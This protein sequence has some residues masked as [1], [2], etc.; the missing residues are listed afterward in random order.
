MLQITDLHLD[1]L[2]KENS[3]TKCNRPLCCRDPPSKSEKNV[4][5]SG[6]YG[7]EGSCDIGEDLFRAF[8]SDASKKD[9]D[10]III[11]GDIVPHDLWYGSQEHV[12]NTTEKIMDMIKEGFKNDIPIYPILGNHEKYPNDLYNDEKGEAELLQKMAEVYRQFLGEEAYNSFKQYGYY[13]M[14]YKNTNLRIVAI[15]CLLCDSMNF[16]LISSKKQRT[17]EMLEWLE[18]VLQNAEDDGEYVYVLNH[19]PLN[20]DFS[21]TECAKRLHALLDRYDYIIR[22]VFSGHTH[23]DDVCQISEY[24]NKSSIINVNFVAPAL[25]T[26]P[27]RLPSYRIYDIDKK[28]MLVRDYTQYRFNL[29]KSNAERSP[30]WFVSHK[31]TELFEVKLMTEY[32]KIVSIDPKKSY[33]DK[34]W[35]SS[36][37][38]KTEELIK[39]AKCTLT[40]NHYDDFYI[41]YQPKF[42]FKNY[43]YI[44]GNILNVANGKWEE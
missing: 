2:Y 37:V 16:M 3:T 19:I 13:T 6:K 35:A 7:H 1:L 24:F 40:S 12:Y 33:V 32:S 5:L 41:C 14:K 39:F 10:F 43:Q 8:V 27:G 28:T 17:M 20:S 9:I 4:K 23:R 44:I 30:Y 11:T 36:Y 25:T 22:G 26:F 34:E 38:N 15:N 42:E 18:R 21:L 31:A 29:T